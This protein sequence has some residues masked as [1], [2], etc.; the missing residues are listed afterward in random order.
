MDKS[1]GSKLAA[2]LSEIGEIHRFD[3]AK[4]LIAFTG[5]E[6]GVYSSGKITATTNA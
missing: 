3:Y 1:L 5:I 4:K 2:T 6:P